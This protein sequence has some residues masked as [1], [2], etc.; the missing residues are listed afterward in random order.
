M[1]IDIILTFFLAFKA[2]Q[3]ELINED[4]NTDELDDL[5]VHARQKKAAEERMSFSA[6]ILTAKQK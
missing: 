6:E 1:I 4:L 3:T 2:N 5:K